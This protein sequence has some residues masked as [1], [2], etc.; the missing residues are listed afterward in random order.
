MTAGAVVPLRG[1]SCENVTASPAVTGLSAAK[2]RANPALL[3][4]YALERRRLPS[5]AQPLGKNPAGRTGSK[6]CKRRA[7]QTREK[8]R[9]AGSMGHARLDALPCYATPFRL[10]GGVFWLAASRA[11]R[12]ARNR[13]VLSRIA[14]SSAWYSAFACWPSCCSC[15]GAT[16]RLIRI[17]A[18]SRNSLGN[19]TEGHWPLDP[20]VTCIKS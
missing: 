12:S 18:Q 5:V 3:R 17:H 6:N 13:A 4:C 19:P 15:F 7:C 11:K 20:K 16:M 14:R 8:P 9:G 1:P 2:A 10:A